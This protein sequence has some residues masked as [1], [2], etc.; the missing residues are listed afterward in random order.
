MDI[1]SILALSL[2]TSPSQNSRSLT[3]AVYMRWRFASFSFSLFSDDLLVRYSHSS[4]SLLILSCTASSEPAH[5]CWSISSVDRA[6]HHGSYIANWREIV[7]RLGQ[8]KPF[9]E[10]SCQNLNKPKIVR[11]TNIVRIIIIS[12]LHFVMWLCSMLL[13]QEARITTVQNRVLYFIDML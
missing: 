13:P 12:G 3:A 1:D 10:L 8:R 2:R 11:K 5:W 6:I 9:Q 4:T 7:H